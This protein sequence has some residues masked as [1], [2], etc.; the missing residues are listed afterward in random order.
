MSDPAGPF[1]KLAL[2]NAWSNAT[3]YAAL[4]A[5]PQDAFDAPRPGFFPSLCRT[6]NHI[7][8]ID[9]YYL[10]ALEEGG[11]GRSVYQRSDIRDPGQLSAA[12]ADAD[13]RL[14]RFCGSLTGRSLAGTRRTERREGVFEERVDML[15]LHLFQHQIH[16]RGQAHVQLQHAGLA[17]PQLDEF[18]L[19]FDRAPSAEAYLG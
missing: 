9:L 16:H 17:P 5:L 12:Q 14:A 4:E 19:A 8:E 11:R 15:L 13:I 1:M 6:M 18:F 3:F 10:D 7:Y 2:N